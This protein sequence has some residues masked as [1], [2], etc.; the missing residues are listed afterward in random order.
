VLDSDGKGEAELHNRL[1]LDNGLGLVACALGG[2][3]DRIRLE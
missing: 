3:L 2:V 1:L